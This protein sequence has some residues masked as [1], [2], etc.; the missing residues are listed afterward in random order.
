MSDPTPA[1]IAEAQRILARRN[2]KRGIAKQRAL[3]PDYAA[4]MRR[5]G[6]LGGQATKAKRAEAQDEA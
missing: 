4:E 1:E 2:S 6:S 3:Y 5:R